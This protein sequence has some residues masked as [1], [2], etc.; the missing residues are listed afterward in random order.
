[1]ST[2]RTERRRDATK[3]QIMGALD[4]DDNKNAATNTHKPAEFLVKSLDGSSASQVKLLLED[5]R[6]KVVQQQQVLSAEAQTGKKEQLGSHYSGMM[7]LPKSIK[8][9]TVREFDQQ[10]KCNLLQLITSV[11]NNTMT[12]KKRIRPTTGKDLETPAP[13]S[14]VA[15]GKAITTPSRTVRRGEAIL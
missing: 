11:T 8:K 10:H 15:G 5:L 6:E 7:K 13:M 4:D 1:M 9:M 14:K 2:S 12:G 3:R